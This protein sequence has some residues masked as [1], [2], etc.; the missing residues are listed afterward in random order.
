MDRKE[1]ME[2]LYEEAKAHLMGVV[3][4]FATPADRDDIL[5]EAHLLFVKA[6]DTYKADKGPF[7]HWLV[8]T[9]RNGLMESL[10]TRLR[11]AELLPRDHVDPDRLARAAAPT[12]DVQD[13]LEGLGDDA[14]DAVTLAGSLW[15][16]GMTARQ[17]R[18]AVVRA[19]KVM[20]WDESR[21]EAAFAE[22]RL[23][24]EG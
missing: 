19:M 16:D 1:R 13:F 9:V 15:A 4:R 7:S 21:V 12:F 2:A 11:R 20:G 6:F 17:A 3:R 24:L 10:R 22:V 8:F 14:L 23:S 5:G 18:Q